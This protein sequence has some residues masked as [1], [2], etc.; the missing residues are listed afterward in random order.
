MDAEHVKHVKLNADR[1]FE[2][3]EFFANAGFAVDAAEAAVD[4]INLTSLAVDDDITC[5][6]LFEP[7]AMLIEV[8]K[9][10]NYDPDDDI[11]EALHEARAAAAE[12]LTNAEERGDACSN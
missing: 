1:I 2:K 11:L 9:W 10:R 12:V 8:L 6:K 4:L 5:R 7:Y 3:L